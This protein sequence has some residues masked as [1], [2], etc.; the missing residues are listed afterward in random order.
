M[1]K[2]ERQKL[3]PYQGESTFIDTLLY[4]YR[5]CDI[6]ARKYRFQLSVSV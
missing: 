5:T 6:G 1:A 3:T 4:D 2:Y